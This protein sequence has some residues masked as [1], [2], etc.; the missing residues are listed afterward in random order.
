[1]LAQRHLLSL[2]N[3]VLNLA[4]VEA[5][6]VD[7]ELQDIAVH[8]LWSGVEPLVAPQLR[9][10][11]L[12]YQVVACDPHVAVRADREKALQVL[13][14]LV[15]NAI[16]FTERGGHITLDTEV[17]DGGVALHV[18]DTGIG[19]PAEKL[20]TVFE[21]FVQGDPGR[22]R[23]GEGV[24]LGLAISRQLARGMGGELTAESEPC[25]G[26]AFTLELP[27]VG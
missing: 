4:R 5:G 20:A 22:A 25:A 18:R 24:G 21:P 11:G 15:T 6:R 10:K 8:E 1:M 12:G 16:K 7:Y 13:L 23:G 14:N 9:A 26:S 2:V 27:R 19:I 3:N 17:R